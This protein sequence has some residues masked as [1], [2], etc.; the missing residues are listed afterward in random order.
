MEQQQS[1]S[2]GLLY[3]IAPENFAQL[4]LDDEAG[5][6]D[7]DWEEHEA[8]YAGDSFAHIVFSFLKITAVKW[9]LSK[10]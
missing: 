4:H 7:F 8:Q 2:P 1:F 3:S 10:P 5:H 6:D 9:G